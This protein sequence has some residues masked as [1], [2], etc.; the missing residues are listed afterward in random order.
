VSAVGGRASAPARP[1]V[2]VVMP[3]AGERTAGLQALE[4]LA[5]IRVG[6]GDQRILVDNLGSLRASDAP[7]GVLVFA[8]EGEGSPAHARNAGAAQARAEWILFLDADT[9]APAD[10]L[11]RYLQAPIEPTV[12]A[13]A[14]EIAPAPGRTVAARYAAA[15]NFLSL[16]AHLS[17][18]YRPRAAA[19]NLLVRRAAF[20]ALGGFFEGLRAAEDTDFCWRLQEAGW[21]L[22]GCP[23][24]VVEHR[25]RGSLRELRSQ[26]RAYA[27]GRAWLARRHPGFRPEP[28][29]ARAL[30]RLLAS[31]RAGASVRPAADVL[32][33]RRGRPAASR[34]AAFRAI[35]TLLA[36]EELV[37]FLLSNRPPGAPAPPPASLVLV[38]ERYPPAERTAPS[39]GAVRVEAAARPE[40]LDPAAG[41]QAVAYREDDGLLERATALARLLGAHP[42][43]CLRERL[44]RPPAAPTLAE[45]APVVARL[46]RDRP[47]ALLQPL[48]PG[49]LDLA[50]ALARLGGRRYAPAP[51]APASPPKREP[52]G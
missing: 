2:S 27:A 39:E 25:Y 46:H 26:W 3:F 21:R 30:R 4:A 19:A 28:A 12:G 50:R 42:L 34:R 40:R 11:E 43:R 8:A 23:D 17:H 1:S 20:E 7:A 5:A 10:L 33:R 31:R 44:G 52:A 16:R 38:A 49:E 24:A 35:D 9:R 6:E 22:A 14:G 15:R 32:E 18:P 36:A 47:G 41:A 45:L 37:G 51:A 13:L 48:G 29:A